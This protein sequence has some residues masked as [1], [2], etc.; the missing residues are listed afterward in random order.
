MRAQRR[1]LPR[2]LPATWQPDQTGRA[3][4]SFFWPFII[5]E[6]PVGGA[7]QIVKLALA[8]C[9]EEPAKPDEAHEQGQRNEESEPVHRADLIRRSELA[10]TISE[11]VD[12]A[13]A[14]SSGVICPAMAKGTA[15]TL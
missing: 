15:K 10:I 1:A 5:D 6:Y 2:Q 4:E 7:F 9:P 12:I 14:A 13:A 11:L 8:Q 3:A